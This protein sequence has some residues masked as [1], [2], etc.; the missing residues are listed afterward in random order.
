MFD[1]I[2]K[3]IYIFI[4]IKLYIIKGSITCLTCPT[5][6]ECLNP[7]SD[8]VPCSTCTSPTEYASDFEIIST[9]IIKEVGYGKINDA[10]NALAWVKF[11][12]DSYDVI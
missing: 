12:F 9:S 4:L 5:K 10:Y 7:A 1:L 3:Q 6:F 2:F 11:L 8:P